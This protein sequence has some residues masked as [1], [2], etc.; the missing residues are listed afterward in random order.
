MSEGDHSPT[1]GTRDL[2]AKKVYHR[3]VR[4]ETQ[5]SHTVTKYWAKAVK[6]IRGRE[7]F[8]EFLATFMLI[9]SQPA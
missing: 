7:F 4:L 9:V 6:V 3:I 5:A 1:T 8:A 2:P